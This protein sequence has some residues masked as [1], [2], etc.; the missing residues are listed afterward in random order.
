MLMP[1]R[2]VLAA[3]LL[4]I[5]AAAC[6]DDT[7]VVDVGPAPPALTASI[8]PA[9][10]T[11]AVGGSVVFAVHAAGGEPGPPAS[12]TCASSNTGIATVDVVE[13]GC[14]A[15]GVAAGS[16]TVTATV[17]RSGGTATV[18][19]QLTVT[20]EA[21]GEPASLIMSLPAEFEDRAL[22]GRV[23]VMLNVERGDRTL[24]RLSLLV[25]GEEVAHRSFADPAAAAEDD[26]A[27][28]QAVYAFTL[29]LDTDAYDEGTG[30]PAF[31]NGE[32][33]ISAEL[34]VA[35][36][37]A[38]GRETISS[39]AVTV[40]F[41]NDDAW[42]VTADLGD[43]SAVGDD[44]R[45]W[46]GGP[47]NGAIQIAALPVR[48]SGDPV[49]AVT[50]NFCSEDVTDSEAPYEFTFR[51][52]GVE[53][54]VGTPLISSGGTSGAILNIDDL[55][56]PAFIDFVGPPGS[57]VIAAN[58]NGREDGWI[59][60]GVSLTAARR[61]DTDD[62][63]LVEPADR[64][65][66]RGVGGYSMTVR[67]GED[68]KAAAAASVP[69]RWPAESRD[70]AAY[71]AVAWAADDLGN[72]SPPPDTTVACRAAPAAADS[73]IDHDDDP[74]TDM[75][76]GQIDEADS[77]TIVA[78]RHLEFGVDTTPP[79]I[80]FAE[81]YGEMR[82]HA[83]LPLTFAFGAHDDGSEIGNSGLDGDAGV[84][85]G[86]QRR[87][88]SR[89]ECLA[90]AEDGSVGAAAAPATPGR[91]CGASVI[92]AMEVTLWTGAAA[93]YRLHAR[94]LDRAGNR[95]NA[96]RHT[97][98]HDGTRAAAT[99]PAVPG[100]VEAGRAFAAASLLNDDLSIR[101]YYMTADFGEVLSLGAG[102]PVGVDGFNA[103]ELTNLNHPARAIIDAYAGLQTTV[104]GAVQALDGVS[105]YVRDQAQEDYGEGERT[106]ITVTDPPERSHGFERGAFSTGWVGGDDAYLYAFCGVPV[107]KDE[108][109]ALA[110]KIEFRAIARAGGPFP[111]PFRR[112]DFWMSDVNGASWFFGSDATGTSGTKGPDRY[113][114]FNPNDDHLPT[115]SFSI[116]VPGTLL[117]A[118]ARTDTNE[119]SGTAP[120]IRAIGVNGNEVGLVTS[121]GVA[122]DMTGPDPAN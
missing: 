2:P 100:A 93:Y 83:A 34:R 59:N 72:E 79:A 1:Y 111:N 11:A 102:G 42:A 81:D 73:L 118:I 12:W 7:R 108:D 39:N 17:T 60:A 121:T 98:L 114:D 13:A 28:G 51:C 76:Y 41:D 22:A 5:G 25:D 15:T 82:G 49:S 117:A 50:V 119:G 44:G 10:A 20:D 101:D 52:E 110:V 63:W 31:M 64:G 107:C 29:P 66:D 92:G 14:R 8:A 84:A 95:S 116:T 96:L 67:F 113:F 85:A 109:A 86:I 105:V 57:P 40:A 19:A 77:D 35:G 61:R 54:G 71:C 106:W 112:V 103:L 30:A 91:D 26:P 78:G 32:Y 47:A 33:T 24:E 68:L 27:A 21:A 48:F 56:F 70:A 65:G 74:R 38:A 90:I 58:P 122:I 94:A 16:V 23:D 53:A 46:Y 89:T 115:W 87:T 43:N 80:R 9:S 120:M 104:G 99:A 88:A 18:G 36:G 45:R 97:F 37:A 6:G 75:V 62:A 55:P 3:G 69:S 4:V